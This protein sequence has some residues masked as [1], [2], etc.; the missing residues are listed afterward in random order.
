MLSKILN[1]LICKSSIVLDIMLLPFDLIMNSKINTFTTIVFTSNGI[2]QQFIVFY[3]SSQM[4]NGERVNL[5]IFNP[6]RCILSDSG[7]NRNLGS[8]LLNVVI[9]PY[10]QLL[11]KLLMIYSGMR[12]LTFPIFKSLVRTVTHLFNLPIGK[13][14]EPLNLLIGLIFVDSSDILSIT[15]RTFSEENLTVNFF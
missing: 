10:Q 7:I 12:N 11:P 15:K 8:M 1:N 4:G 6:L 2:I 13:K 14:L 9:Y 5:T 3:E